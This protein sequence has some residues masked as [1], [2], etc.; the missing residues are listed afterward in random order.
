MLEMPVE[1]SFAKANQVSGLTRSEDQAKY[2]IAT[3]EPVGDCRT[4]Q[5]N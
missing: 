3:E 1:F 5:H 2:A 4:F